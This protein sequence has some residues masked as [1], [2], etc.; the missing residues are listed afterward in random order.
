MPVL[1]HLSHLGASLAQRSRQSASVI[2][3]PGPLRSPGA[4][5]ASGS[6]GA[7]HIS[8]AS[9]AAA[10]APPCPT[11]A[12]GRAAWVIRAGD[13]GNPLIIIVIVC[14][15]LGQ[16]PKCPV[17]PA[18]R[19][20]PHST[21][22]HCTASHRRAPRTRALQANVDPA[23]AF[24]LEVP[25]ISLAETVA[26][27][28]RKDGGGQSYYQWELVTPASA[29]VLVSACV[30]GGALYVLA[31]EASGDLWDRGSK[32]RTARAGAW[33]AR[34]IQSPAGSGPTGRSQILSR[35]LSRNLSMP[36]FEPG[37]AFGGV[38]VRPVR[39]G[40]LYRFVDL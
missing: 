21:A 24:E 5:G 10:A 23:R 6:D 29:H 33:R 18:A 36:A 26:S 11:F 9:G 3:E 39:G 17:Y 32:A 31:I 1:G 25:D 28:A 7:D 40:R 35:N 38:L 8:G 30:S 16:Y 4:S 27:S 2:T 13:Q 19:A 37:R 22:S 14:G 34:R 15:Q 12:P 20:A